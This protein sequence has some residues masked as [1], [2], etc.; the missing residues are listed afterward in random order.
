MTRQSLLMLAAAVLALAAIPA[1][2]AYALSLT[3]IGATEQRVKISE[4]GDEIV[5]QEVTLG[6]G[7]TVDGL[8]VEGCTMAL[9]GG[10][11]QSFEGDENVHI[12]DGRFVIEQ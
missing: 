6:A 2:Q 9:E 12:E 10:E 7:Q 5:T 8:C 11:Q 4:G 3:N 1:S